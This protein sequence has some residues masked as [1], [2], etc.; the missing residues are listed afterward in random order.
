[1]SGINI[2][3][4]VILASIAAFARKLSRKLLSKFQG[5]LLGAALGNYVGSHFEHQ[6]EKNCQSYKLFMNQHK[7]D[8]SKLEENYLKKWG[9]ITMNCAKSLIRKQEFNEEDL[10]KVH[11]EWQNKW[12]NKKDYTGKAN[13]IKDSPVELFSD[14]F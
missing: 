2:K 3:F 10:Q 12:K 6:V 14:R 4:P 7:F 1:M 13:K 5:A 8:R 9:E 11:K